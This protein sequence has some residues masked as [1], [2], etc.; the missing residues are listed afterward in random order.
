[1][2]DEYGFEIYEENQFPLAYL[3][4]FRTYGTWLHGDERYSVDRHRK[5]IFETP[6]IL[7]NENLR[8][9]MEQKS[10]NSPLILDVRQRAAVETAICNLCDKR[11]Y[12]LR[13]INVR[14]NHVHV[15]LSFDKSP[16]PIITA[17]K[18]FSTK[19]LREENLIER[20]RR[21]WSRGG[22]RRY[23]WKPRHVELAKKYVLYGQG[24]EPFDEFE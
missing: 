15:V 13:A 4:T 6:R 18:A 16:E 12:F 10:L 7:P 21:V 8:N 24:D 19:Q 22:S 23:L 1:M 11:K 9:L 3:L 20:E 17:L 14:S 5:N 2:L